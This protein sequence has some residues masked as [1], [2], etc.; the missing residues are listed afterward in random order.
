MTEKRS[1][2]ILGLVSFARDA[3]KQNLK[4]RSAAATKGIK[5]MLFARLAISLTFNLELF[6]NDKQRAEFD[7]WF[8]SQIDSEYCSPNVKALMYECWQAAIASVVVELPELEKH[9]KDAVTEKLDEAG[10][11]YE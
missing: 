3:K 5:T 6:M 10:I 9:D 11:R 4:K 2:Q 7:K 1:Y 8:N